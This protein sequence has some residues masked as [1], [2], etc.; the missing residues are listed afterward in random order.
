MASQNESNVSGGRSTINSQF[1]RVQTPDGT[2]ELQNLV[3]P[4]GS[5]ADA[6]THGEMDRIPL[7]EG[8]VITTAIMTSGYRRIYDDINKFLPVIEDPSI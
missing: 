4:D 3:S 5:G 2:Q 7:P 1:G 8:D 6:A